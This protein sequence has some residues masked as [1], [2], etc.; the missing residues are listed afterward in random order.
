[1]SKS[2]GGTVSVG[3]LQVILFEDEL[4]LYLTIFP[5]NIEYTI[6]F[7]KP[8]FFFFYKPFVVQFEL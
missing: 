6:Q 3:S 8:F 5:E 7:Q 2:T 4:F 1:M